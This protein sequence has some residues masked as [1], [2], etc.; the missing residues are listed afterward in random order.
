MNESAA[1]CEAGDA[2]GWPGR[3][4]RLAVRYPCGLDTVC[5]IIDLPGAEVLPAW[6]RDLSATGVGLVTTRMFAP[7]AVVGIELDNPERGLRRRIPA[8]VVY[9]IECP[10]DFW[11]HGCAFVNP[12][13]PE[14]M[15]A[16]VG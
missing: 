7:G 6:V 8:R 3:E 9:N 13:T 4:R 16:L 1:A 15:A 10:G 5:N 12:L 14:E 11:L 2:Q